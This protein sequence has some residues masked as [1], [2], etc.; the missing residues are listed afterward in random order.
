MRVGGGHRAFCKWSVQGNTNTSGGHGHTLLVSS[1]DG[2]QLLLAAVDKDL[3]QRRPARLLYT[4]QTVTQICA[5]SVLPMGVTVKKQP[6]GRTK[7]EGHLWQKLMTCLYACARVH[8]TRHGR[9][10]RQ[11]P[12]L[13]L[14]CVPDF[15]DVVHEGCLHQR[16][17]GPHEVAGRLRLHVLDQVAAEQLSGV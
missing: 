5:V 16:H 13:H 9:A 6:S 14:E 11:K 10:V 2:S 8:V 12:R 1:L 17:Q 4:S 15:V 7:Q 3:N